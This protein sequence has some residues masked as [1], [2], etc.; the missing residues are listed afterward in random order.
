[1]AKTRKR[2]KRGGGIK[3]GLRIGGISIFEWIDGSTQ[4]KI[5]SRTTKFDSKFWK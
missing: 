2:N 1:M 4:C 3:S 5:T